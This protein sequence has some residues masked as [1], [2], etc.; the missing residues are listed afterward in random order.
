MRDDEMD[1]NFFDC[2]MYF[3]LSA[4][5]HAVLELGSGDWWEK[6]QERRQRLMEEITQEI[7]AVE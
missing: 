5:F 3:S 7:R 2:L 1:I 4:C 6:Q